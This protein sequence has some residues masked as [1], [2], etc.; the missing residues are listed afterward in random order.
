[1][2]EEKIKLLMEWFV[3]GRL[4]DSGH[5]SLIKVLA[6]QMNFLEAYITTKEK[7]NDDGELRKEV[8]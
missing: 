8:K 6:E 2:N 3:K 1:M 4:N 7:F 5:I